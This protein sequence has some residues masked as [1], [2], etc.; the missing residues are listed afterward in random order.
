M[1]SLN[2]GYCTSSYSRD[3]D[4]SCEKTKVQN[5]EYVD[6]KRGCNY[7]IIHLNDYVDMCLYILVDQIS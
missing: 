3:L 2:L 7:I 6:V 5:K 4:S 1:F